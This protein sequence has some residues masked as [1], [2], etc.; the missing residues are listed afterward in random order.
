[1][2]AY[3]HKNAHQI[4]HIHTHT[5][6][7]TISPTQTRGIPGAHNVRLYT[8]FMGNNV[9]LADSESS[10]PSWML[11]PNMVGP[12]GGGARTNRENFAKNSAGNSGGNDQ[13]TLAV[14][15]MAVLLQG[16]LRGT[17]CFN[18]YKCMNVCMYVLPL[19]IW[20]L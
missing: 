12:G 5:N 10:M 8:R 13:Q 18:M 1:M 20:L 6:I 4:T 11:N 19:E 16:D 9:G 7:L 2:Y 15:D 17:V 14:G 3:T